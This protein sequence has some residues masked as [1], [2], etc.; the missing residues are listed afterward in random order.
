MVLPDMHGTELFE[1]ILSSGRAPETMAFVSE[2][3]LPLAQLDR[4]ARSG[5]RLIRKDRLASGKDLPT[6][7]ALLA[8]ARVRAGAHA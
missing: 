7:K 5:V 6:L 8:D 3:E 4:L 2:C 1:R